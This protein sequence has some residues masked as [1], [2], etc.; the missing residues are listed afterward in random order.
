M[1]VLRQSDIDFIAGQVVSETVERQGNALIETVA[2]NEQ[3][4]KVA[5]QYIN[6]ASDK[7][8]GRMFEIIE[9]TKFNVN[10]AKAGSM[11]RAVTT[12][13]L[14]M[15]HHEAD[16]FIRNKSGDV[17]REV[18]AK[19]G[20]NPVALASYIKN[21]KYEGMDRLVNME[22]KNRVSELMESRIDKQGIYAEDYRDAQKHLKGQLEYDGIKSGGTTHD[23][24]THAAENPEAFASQ[25]NRAE[26]ISGVKNAML[27]GAL[28]G[29]FVGGTINTAQGL[30]KGEFC[31]KETGKGAANSAARGAVVS[32][33]SYGL[34]Y[35]GKNNAVMTGNVVTSLASSAVNMTELTYK[36]LTKKITT[37]A[38]VEGLG[39]NAVSCF[40]G[41]IMT[42]AGAALFGPI[43]AAI[44]GTVALIGIKQ[45]YK[46]FINAREDLKL[47][48][49]ARIQAEALSEI[50]IQQVKEEEALLISYYKEYEETFVK[51]K[52][53]VDLAIIDDRL[54]EKAIISLVDGLNI[55]FKYERL[56]DFEAFMLSD[57][58]LEL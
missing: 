49:E 25:M 1:V 55:K 43:G 14:G 3:L 28:A 51:L 26:F 9:S 48:K 45:L 16:I 31:V 6:C 22:H 27:S 12:D 15:P 18:Q 46:V 19:S 58:V 33:V 40:S 44:A 8:Q 11:L 4:V 7:T 23:E 2:G 17:L 52:Q 53:L 38:Y 35:L 29:A 42:A 10:A 20:N 30:F 39:S 21:K 47:S 36:F 41:I 34:K 56:D 32:G 37:E 54:T 5:K 24:A 13:Q 57:E 50:I